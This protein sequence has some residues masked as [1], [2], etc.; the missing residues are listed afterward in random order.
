MI[1]VLL[2]AGNDTTPLC[3]PHINEPLYHTKTDYFSSAF[4]MNASVKEA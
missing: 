4:I 1:F 3:I 2:F